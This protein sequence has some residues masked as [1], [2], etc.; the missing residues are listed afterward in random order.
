MKTATTFYFV[1]ITLDTVATKRD[2]GS[3]HSGH[4]RVTKKKINKIKTE[5]RARGGTERSGVGHTSTSAMA[6]H[7]KRKKRVTH[8]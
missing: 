7:R 2:C 8:K 6:T 4:Q 3:R 1:F 5:R